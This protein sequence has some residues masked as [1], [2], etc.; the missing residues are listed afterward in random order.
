MDLQTI[1]KLD[2]QY[3]INTFGKRTPVCFDHGSGITL[4]D[5]EGVAY[6]DFFGGIA[7]NSLGYGH[8]GLT[9]ALTEQVQKLLH[10]SNL[11]YNENQTL[12]AEK[13]V[14]H[15]VADKIFFANC[16]AEANESAIKLA[17]MYFY[18]KNRPEKNEIITLQNSF[19][20][21]TL[22]CVAATGQEKYQKPYAPLTPGFSHVP[23]NDF[24]ALAQAADETKTAAVMLE[25]IQGE[26]GVNPLTQDYVDR[27]AALCRE[28]DILLIVDEVQTGMGRT[29][30]WF[31]YEHYGLVPDIFTLAKGLGGGV[32]IGAVCARAEVAAAFS[33]GDHGGTFGGGPLAS[34]A[35]LA[36][37]NAFEAERLPENSKLVGEYLKERLE[38]LGE[39]SPVRFGVRGMGLMLGIVFSEPIA[40]KLQ[41]ALF[42][43]KYLVGAVGDSVL[44]LL[45]P[46]ILQKK[47][48]DAF[49]EVL[50]SVLKNL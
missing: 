43:A 16:G 21:R 35:G 47:D 11:Y 12:L 30:A 22:A 5:T 33:P 28:K 9:K 44:R 3:Y 23:I 4:Y 46:L 39:T 10:V 36:V 48:V 2:E 20:G 14:Q 15:S 19:H 50:A 32:P 6:T 7:V 37:C 29:G 41:Q 27:L 31:C 17:K 18:K 1:I 24:E 49:C 38:A 13:L 26:S 25:L 8:K 34:C 42:E 40:K 45:P